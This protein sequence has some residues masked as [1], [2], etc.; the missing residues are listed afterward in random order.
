M[1]DLSTSKEKGTPPRLSTVLDRL[2]EKRKTVAPGIGR[3]PR[4]PAGVPLSFA[5]QR[6]WFMEQLEPGTAIYNIPVAM[7]LTGRL[8]VAALAR[9]LGESVRRHEALCTV[10]RTVEG[11]PVQVIGPPA[12]V[13]VPVVDLTGPSLAGRAVSPL[14]LADARRTFDLENG[15]LLRAT[16]LRLG[17]EHHVLL[18]SLH[19]LVGDA[20]SVAVLLQELIAHYSAALAGKAAILPELP[21]QYPDFALWQRDWLQGEVLERY[22]TTWRRRLADSPP[23]LDLP[24]DRPRPARRSNAGRRIPL[25]L[26]AA[27]VHRLEKVA[28]GA[29]T[30]LF[31]V[32][33]AAFQVLLY[34]WS[35]AGDL[36]VGT[37]VA[38]RR[39]SEVQGLVGLF[40]N[41]LAMRGS[42][43]GRPT[44][45]A[46]LQHTH[47]RVVEAQDHQELPFEKLVEELQ[48]ERTTSHAPLFQVILAFQNVPMPRVAL[49]GCTIETQAVDPGTSMFDLTLNLEDRGDGLG[50]WW[51]YS[52]A[53]FDAT[54]LARLDA[55]FHL[56]MAGLEEGIDL[57]LEELPFLTGPERHQAEREWNDTAVFR[58]RELLL[59]RLVAAQVERT[60]DAEAVAAEGAGITERVTYREL[61]RRADRLAHRLREL[62]VGPDVP[63]GVFAERSVAM[64]VALLGILEAGGAYAP[65]DPGYPAERLAFMARTARMPVI[66]TQSHLSASVPEVGAAVVLVD[67]EP[68]ET[69]APRRAPWAE[70]TGE[71]LAYVIF[72]SGSTGQPKGAM[73]PHAG[74][75]NRLLWMQETYGLG[76]GDRVL[77]KTPFSFDVSVWEF[78]W[79][80]LSGATL[81][82]ARPGGHQDPAYL[83]ATIASEKITTLHFVPSM[84]QVFLAQEDIGPCASLRHVMVSGEALPE[85]LR[86]RF[87]DR[88]PGVALHNLY[89]PTEASVDVTFW[90]CPRE[91]ERGLVPIGQPIA[92]TRIYVV[93]PAFHPVPPGAPGE[94]LIGGVSLARGYLGRPDLT[95]ERFVPDPFAPRP[96][97][98]LYRTGDLVRHLPD[99]AI[100]YLGRIDHQVKLRGIRIELGEIEAA[101][102]ALTGVS[103]A[104]VIVREDRSEKGTGDRRLVAYVA[105]DADAETL[106]RSLRERL[107]DSMVPAAFVILAA[108]PLS[109]NGKVDRKALPAPEWQRPAESHEEPR[110]PVEEVLA[111]IWAELLGL[112]RI[113]RTDHFF[114]LGG[115]SLLATQVMSRLRG[116]FG[117]EMPLHDLLE[118]PRL[119]DLAT[120]VE[121]ARLTGTDRLLAPPLVPIAPAAR[122]GPL[123]LSF[124]QQRLWFIDQL[125]PG[126]P[127]Y[128]IP[129]ALRVEGPLDPAVLA[130]CLGEIVRRHEALRT[131]FAMLEGEPVQVIQPAASFV[132]PVV[133]LSGLPESP[134]EALS[135]AL[136]G[137]EAV[138]PFDLTCDPLLRGVLLRLAEEDHLASLT[139]HHIV[140]DGWSLGILI[141]EV[142][143]LYPR[144][145]A[146]RPSPLPELAMQYVDFAAWQSSWLKGEILEREIS[147]WRRQL[148]GLPP[149]LELPTDRPRPAVQSYR[150]ASRPVY[151]PAELIRQI[152][153]L[154]RREGA[155][156]FMVLLAAFQTLLARYS[157]QQDLAVGTPVAGRNR[158]EIEGLIGFFINTLVLRGD[159]AGEPSFREL[160]GRVRETSLAAHTHQDMPFE[161]LVQELSPE[162]SL[163]QTPLFQVV[164]VLHNAPVK[165]LEIQGL[166]LRP[167]DTAT[168]TSKFDL[169][170]NLADQNGGL[171]GTVKYATDLFDATTI[172]RLILHYEKLLTA[173]LAA[174]GLLASE[175][176]LLNGAERHQIILEWGGKG[177]Q[178]HAALTL[179]GRFAAQARQM[180][181]A[182]ALICGDE[183]MSYGELDSRS[184]QLARRLRQQGAD[185][186]S[187]VGLCLERSL[188]LVV[189]ILGILKAGARLCA[190]RSRLPAGAAGLHDRGRGHPD[191]GGD[192]GVRHRASGHGPAD[193]PRHP[194]R[195]A[196]GSPCRGSRTP[197]GWGEP[198]LCDLHFGLHRPSQGRSGH[199]RQRRPALRR[200]RGVVRLRRTGCLD[201]VPLVCLRLFGLGDLG[202][203]ALRWPIGDR[204]LGSEPF[205]R[206]VPGSAAPRAGHRAQSNPL[207]LRPPRAGGREA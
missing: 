100:D 76:P 11:Q 188:D 59:H 74:I 80:L 187:R 1:S 46:F 87:Y 142:A 143:A 148:A 134:R 128:S 181:A 200:H 154:S 5:Q 81:V 48:P 182:T 83:S 185:L 151:L 159:M 86:R 157:G 198:G 68:E 4:D 97:E 27:L 173:A 2:R 32:V 69:G 196:G 31:T 204:P 88:L 89:G 192:E 120:R 63:V 194:P 158:L 10:F 156:L 9:S 197:G 199:P 171:G 28:R 104:V 8:D 45:R 14:M 24:T 135:L 116:A 85:E 82:M 165:N 179:H 66:L 136:A 72:T 189:G 149:R 145:A 22:L 41:M 62:G 123:P 34:R 127:L 133:D 96:G 161:K 138:R 67:G 51:E 160:L 125:E 126:S 61:G 183:S 84:L 176:P 21:L 170:L 124:A 177:E 36:V 103:Q 141:R 17:P 71:S 163:A 77:Q 186:E 115:H 23:V 60:P 26:S 130:L 29:G 18:V 169:T 49:P 93:D 153:A 201:S 38:N 144:F 205:A 99:G 110:T 107:P 139:M 79:P 53:L 16:L 172:D 113:G 90:A 35:G 131:V 55:R 64:V 206:A 140:S 137:R 119:A 118:A 122:K 44:F 57:P 180:P 20:W 132:L 15:P 184:N 178:P 7:T 54:T 166:R 147:F 191:R 33:L 91:N 112:D 70:L 13:A 25:H 12:P 190:A 155:T 193:S 6:I 150:G 43:R 168:T 162:R 30:T 58:P 19:H 75:C 40:V 175:L 65:L 129:V 195:D 39:R 117:I 98:R 114:D 95:G 37:P 164:F 102:S 52:T 146:G 202:S 105:G 108:L 167:L 203:A 50:G 73:L 109:P 94:L 3:R 111:G 207:G 152:Q 121:A 42:L 174:P 78:F 56:L 47:E 92:N 101:L 106:R